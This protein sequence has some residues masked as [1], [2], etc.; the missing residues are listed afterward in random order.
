MVVT[1]TSPTTPQRSEVSAERPTDQPIISVVKSPTTCPRCQAQ[2]SANYDEA[3]C[4]QCGYVDYN[5]T[6]QSKPSTGRGSLLS[7]GTR[8]IIRYMGEFHSLDATLIDAKLIRAGNRAV[9]A[10]IC[11]FCDTPRPMI[12]SSFSNRRKRVWEDHYKC[13]IGHRVSLA[14]GQRGII[15]WK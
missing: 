15:G 3:I 14:S 7:S 6:D 11:P 10:I 12:L 13:G 5:Y 9:Y 8:S 4:M 2:L 1:I